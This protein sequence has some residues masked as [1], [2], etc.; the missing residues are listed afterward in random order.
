MV[1]TVVA[2]LIF[3][4]FEEDRGAATP[5]FHI[6]KQGPVSDRILACHSGIKGDARSLFSS[7]P[8]QVKC[9]SNFA[10]AR[11]GK[12]LLTRLCLGSFEGTD[13]HTEGQRLCQHV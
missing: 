11:A 7:P 8:P 5:T 6:E 13:S 9:L 3:G 10:I 2:L 4:S 1:R 12:I